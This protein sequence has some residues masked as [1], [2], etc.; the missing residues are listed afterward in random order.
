MEDLELKNI[1]AAYDKKLEEAKILNLQSWALNLKCF[2]ELQLHKAKSK[3]RALAGF[4]WGVIV[5]SIAYVLFLSMLVYFIRWRNIYFTVSIGMIALITMITLVTYI[6]HIVIISQINYS[7]SITDTQGKLSILR[8]SM[9]N[10]VRIAWLQLPFWSTFFWSSKWII[11]GS[12][13]FWLIPL[14][15]TLFLTWLAIWLYRNVS[16]KNMDRAWF[17]ILLGSP[18]WTS[19]QKALEFMR[20]I[21]VF[22]QDLIL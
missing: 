1:W 20:E 18:E 7:N 14:P 4:R 12:L 21:E 19:V 9:I 16:L 11:Y 5:L 22:K 2:E 8:S 13:S 17:K 10:I 15:I 3:L 6:K